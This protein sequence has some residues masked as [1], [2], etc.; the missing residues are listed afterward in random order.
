ML[1]KIYAVRDQKVESYSQPFFAH[2]HGESERSFEQAVKTPNSPYN[3][4]PQD[5]DLYYLGT[6]D[7]QT[8]AIQAL[9]TPEFITKAID[10]KDR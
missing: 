7:D 6:Y 2:T 9:Q 5:F 4:F 3:Q 8:G 1:R 10:V